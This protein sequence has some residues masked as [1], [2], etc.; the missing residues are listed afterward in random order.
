MFAELC[1][2]AENFEHGHFFRQGQT[3]VFRDTIQAKSG[4]DR[5]APLRKEVLQFGLSSKSQ[6][7]LGDCTAF[8]NRQGCS[9]LRLFY[10]CPKDIS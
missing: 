8:S 9:H 4:R 2:L 7:V 1:N 10:A 5:K 3:S 6:P